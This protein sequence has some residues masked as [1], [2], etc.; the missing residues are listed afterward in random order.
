[1]RLKSLHP[2]LSRRWIAFAVISAGLLWAGVFAG[3]ETFKRSAIT[4]VVEETEADAE[5]KRALLLAVLDRSRS[6]P[7]V[8]AGD[9]D[10]ARTLISQQ[11]EDLARLNGKLQALAEE[12][13]ASAIYVIRLDG[14]AIS[15]SNWNQ[16]DSF[17]GSNYA[18]RDYFSR[19]VASGSAEQYALGS[20][21]RRPGL[22][23]SRRVTAGDGAPLGVVVVKV[24][25]D[26]LEESWRRSGKLTFVTDSHGIVLITSEPSWR[27]LTMSD[28]PPKELSQIRDSLQ[29]GEAPLTP[30]PIWSLHEFDGYP[31][32]A[33]DIEGAMPR[34]PH[35]STI[36]DVPG[37]AWTL[38]VLA[39]AGTALDAGI[40]EGRLT[41]VSIGVPLIAAAAWLLYLSGRA[42]RRR[43]AEQAAR[44]ELEHQVGRRTLELTE[45][46]DRLQAEIAEHHATDS[47]L[48]SV[49]QDLV[50]A[51]RLA[52]LGQVAAGV[53]HEINQPV[54][55]IRAYADNANAFLDRGDTATATENL[56]LI[57]DLTDRIGSITSQLRGLA[58][59]GRLVAEP[60]NL[61]AAVQGALFLL[62]SRFSGSMD[63][64]VIGP[65]P[66]DLTVTGQRVR[67][68]QVLIN[69]FQNALEALEGKDGARIEV[70]VTRVEDDDI[71]LTVADNGPGIPQAIRDNLFI[72]FNTSK[73]SG[74]GLGLVIA[75]DIVTEYGGTITAE[76][77]TEGT[78]FT[79]TLKRALS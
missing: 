51:N 33:T 24:E 41:A 55:T 38:R 28:I 20:V 30:V 31:M 21:S 1:M 8:L 12:T 74:L 29:F 6:L 4:G 42:A 35:F 54:A 56:G 23:L 53:A 10:L 16:P 11:P 7:L 70:N 25:F 57:A 27:F 40:W 45:A 49:Q 43:A 26:Q 75:R 50:Q 73:D 64:L 47:R 18:F 22:Y 76:S 17:V 58:R 2:M 34:Q 69:L 63:M 66:D 46:R 79:V 61:K 60:V 19:A 36:M 37:T 3:Q 67:L 9:T 44:A 68:E 77:S 32:V 71:T 62:R 5:L 48:Q 59:K 78:T 15:A 13:R 39:P 52:I 72:P 65:I 14:T